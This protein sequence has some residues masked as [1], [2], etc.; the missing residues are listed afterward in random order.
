MDHKKLRA[1]CYAL[2]AAVFYA[3]NVP[4]SKLLLEKIDPTCLAA[5]LY[6]GTG[7]GIGTLAIA[8]A[9]HE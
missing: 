2:A 7:I 6:L 3:I 1:V 9:A 5:L 8:F 4:C